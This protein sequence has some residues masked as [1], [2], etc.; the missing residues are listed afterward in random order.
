MQGFLIAVAGVFLVVLLILGGCWAVPQY[1]VWQKE[2]SGK[3]KLREAE[4]SR[5][6]KVEEAKA[7][8]LSS[9][10][11]A[12]AEI[13]R[14]RGVAE[15]NEIIG[16][17]LQGNEAYLRYLWIQGLHDGTSETIYIATEANLPILE[18]RDNR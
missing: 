8:K 3:A 15:A 5:Q 2:L 6:I 4:W 13:I 1:N 14:A 9:T 11:L 7:A 12:E 16:N 18:A 17:S 10:E